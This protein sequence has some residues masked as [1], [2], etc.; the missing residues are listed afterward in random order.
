VEKRCESICRLKGVDA[1]PEDEF[2]RGH[3]HH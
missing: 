1:A 3:S 2:L